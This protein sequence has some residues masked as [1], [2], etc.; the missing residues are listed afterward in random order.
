MYYNKKKSTCTQWVHTRYHLGAVGHDLLVEGCQTLL[1]CRQIEWNRYE[2]G[3]TFTQ[4]IAPC[5][6]L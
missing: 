2:V 4:S 3:D 1:Q 6:H 5:D